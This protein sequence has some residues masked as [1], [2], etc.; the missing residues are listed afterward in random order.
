LDWDGPLL[1]VNGN[2]FVLV[3]GSLV[4]GIELVYETEYMVI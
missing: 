3:Q 4:L 2:L 1:V